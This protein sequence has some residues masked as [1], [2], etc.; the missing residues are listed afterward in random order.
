MEVKKYWRR[1]TPDLPVATYIGIAGA[2]MEKW[3]KEAMCHSEI[4]IMLIVKG[5]I[6]IRIGQT[7]NTFYA[8]DFLSSLAM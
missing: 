3:S 7:K 4:E 2:N 8:G 1:G 6:R 5:S